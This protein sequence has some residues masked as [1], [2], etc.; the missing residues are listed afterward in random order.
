ML[1]YDK[2][3]LPAVKQE[4]RKGKDLQLHGL[5]DINKLIHY[6]PILARVNEE[7]RYRLLC[8]KTTSAVSL[9]ISYLIRCP[10]AYE[11]LPVP[12][13]VVEI[14]KSFL[15]KKKMSG[16][17]LKELKKYSTLDQQNSD[18]DAF[19]DE[20]TA[21]LIKS[22]S[23]SVVMKPSYFQ[24]Q[25]VGDKKQYVLTQNSRGFN[26]HVY[27]NGTTHS[28]EMTQLEVDVLQVLKCFVEWVKSMI[29]ID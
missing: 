8:P 12:P 1:T 10:I 29:F 13:D 3:I 6:Y 23:T 14:L 15:V 2:P 4:M 24:C 5:D 18:S 25:R 17:P 9:I 22:I 26:L 27:L 20:D 7:R 19:I 11:K 21:L 16:I 28:I